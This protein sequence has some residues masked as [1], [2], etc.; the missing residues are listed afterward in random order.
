MYAFQ[1]GFHH[2]KGHNPPLKLG[3]SAPGHQFP[4]LVTIIDQGIKRISTRFHFFFYRA[5]FPRSMHSTVCPPLL[6]EGQRWKATNGKDD[7]MT[8]GGEGWFSVQS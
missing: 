4:R 3:I 6:H 7:D 2:E 5:M 8:K 1:N